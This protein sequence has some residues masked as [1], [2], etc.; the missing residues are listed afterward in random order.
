MPGLLQFHIFSISLA[1]KKYTGATNYRER[2]CSTFTPCGTFIFSGSEDGMA[3]VWNTDTGEVK[4]LGDLRVFCV[5]TQP[6]NLSFVQVMQSP[7]TLSSVIPP[8][9]TAWLSTLMKTW[10]PSVPSDSASLSTCICTITK[11]CSESLFFF[12]PCDVQIS[13]QSCF[14]HSVPAGGS[15]FKSSHSNNQTRPGRLQKHQKS[16]G[17]PDITGHVY[18]FSPGPV[19]PN[20]K[21]GLESQV[22]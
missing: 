19:C 14:Y 11:V 20:N 16:T 2:I 18:G 4:T 7:S 6:V 13:H 9:S 10:L 21:A 1:M 5:E 3:Y 17:K 15:Q 8:L 22:C 12:P